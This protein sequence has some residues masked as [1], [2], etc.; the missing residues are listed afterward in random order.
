MQLNQRLVKYLPQY[1]ISS[2]NGGKEDQDT[3]IQWVEEKLSHVVK[4]V[5]MK[6]HRPRM[7]RYSSRRPRDKV[8]RQG[9]QLRNKHDDIL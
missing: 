5:L 9:P 6:D 1:N 4:E 3:P 8:R 7:K 2:Y